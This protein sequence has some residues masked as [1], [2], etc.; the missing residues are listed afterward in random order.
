MMPMHANAAID[1][2]GGFHNVHGKLVRDPEKCLYPKC[3]ICIDHCTMGYNDYPVIPQNMAAREIAVMT[4]TDALTVKCSV[5]QAQFTRKSP[6]NRRRRQGRIHG[7]ELFCMV[8]EK[9]EKEGKF[10]RLIPFDKVGTK[11]PFYS[12]HNTHP[13]LKPLIDKSR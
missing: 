1:H 10:R 2:L 7:S 8:L 13:R 6:M 12:V 3:H 9:A 11:T 5:L 4:D